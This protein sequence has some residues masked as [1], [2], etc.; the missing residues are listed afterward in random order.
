PAKPELRP[1]RLQAG[2]WRRGPPAAGGGVSS[3]SPKPQAPSLAKRGFDTRTFPRYDRATV[4]AF[5]RLPTQE[6]LM[7]MP[8]LLPKSFQLLPLVLAVF[9][10]APLRAADLEAIDRTILKEPAYR[11]EPG[12]CLLVFGAEAKTRVW[13]VVDGPRLFVDRNANGDLT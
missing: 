7:A 11:S 5:R 2:A 10:A 12:Y 13:L 8:L 6:F 3:S 1:A 4:P 9:A